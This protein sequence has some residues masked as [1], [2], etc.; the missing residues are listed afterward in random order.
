MATAFDRF[1]GK[2]RAEVSAGEAKAKAAGHVSEAIQRAAVTTV[3]EVPT[4]SPGVTNGKGETV[5]QSDDHILAG[6]GYL[7]GDRLVRFERPVANADLAATAT[8]KIELSHENFSHK[9]EYSFGMAVRINMTNTHATLDVTMKHP[10]GFFDWI[11]LQKPGGS[12]LAHWTPEF[13]MAQHFWGLSCPEGVTQLNNTYGVIGTAVGGGSVVGNLEERNHF[14][15]LPQ[16]LRHIDYANLAHPLYLVLKTAPTGCV[17]TG[18]A[19]AVAN[20]VPDDAKCG[21][22]LYGREVIQKEIDDARD[23]A[24]DRTQMP[25]SLH[26]PDIVVNASP[27]TTL[28]AATV[29][30]ISCDLRGVAGVTIGHLLQLHDSAETANDVPLQSR[31]MGTLGGTVQMFDSANLQLLPQEIPTHYYYHMPAHLRLTHSNY[32][33]SIGSAALSGA[34]MLPFTPGG[35]F[36]DWGDGAASKSWVLHPGIPKVTLKTGT[37]FDAVTPGVLTVH[38]IAL[39]RIR[40]KPLGC[41]LR[42]S[43]VLDAPPTRT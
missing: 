32:M 2:L 39:R 28:T 18:S 29:N 17:A 38:T 25:F 16:V 12:V 43:D 7:T 3:V 23:F 20:V 33:A 19:V 31:F 36:K 30:A 21:L 35:K 24:H 9:F 8:L 5:S 41:G 27:P 34:N 42:V 4:P 37:D 15:Y 10:A 1:Q 26:L 13:L 11:E 22:M 14:L 40:I 6:L